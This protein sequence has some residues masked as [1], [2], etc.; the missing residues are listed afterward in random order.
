VFH[1][2]LFSVERAA[3]SER[4]ADDLTGPIQRNSELEQTARPEAD[5]VVIER[6]APVGMPA[7]EHEGGGSAVALEFFCK[8]FG[9]ARLHLFVELGSEIG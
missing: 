1:T 2:P 8:T 7:L 6:H 5:H 3:L 4:N 9:Q